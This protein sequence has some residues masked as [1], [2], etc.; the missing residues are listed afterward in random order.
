M[1]TQRNRRRRLGLGVSTIVNGTLEMGASPIFT[2]ARQ[3]R[4]VGRPVPIAP[5]A[6]PGGNP[7]NPWGGGAWGNPPVSGPV[8]VTLP[9]GSVSPNGGGWQAPWGGRGGYGGQYNE[10]GSWNPSNP[11]NPT[12]ANN[13]AQLT[14]QYQTN[15]SSLTEQQWQ[16]LQAAGVIAGTV[17]YSNASL[18]SGS[19]TGAIDPNT[20]QPYAT[21]LAAA[22]A[23]A[24]GG[25]TAAVAGTGLS[26]DLSTEY[27]GIPL[28]LWLGGGALL[29]VL[30]SGKRR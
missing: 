29:F 5:V 15:P 20:G 30:M 17:P 12:S 2:T 22:E 4:P 23:A 9:G 7:T 8:P 13:L 16:Q 25:T 19:G 26:T 28:Y 24:A 1:F 21:E 6:F 27:A 10:G 3:I 18:V 11:N 14:L